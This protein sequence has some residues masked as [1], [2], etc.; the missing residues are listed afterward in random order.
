[1]RSV[2]KGFAEHLPGAIISRP[3]ASLYSVVDLRDVAPADFDASDF[4]GYCARQGR[5]QLDGED[6]TLL[7]AP[8]SGFYG[9]GYP[10]GKFQMRLAY[11]ESPEQMG[12]V[13]R[14][15]AG[16]FAAYLKR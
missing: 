16:L 1:M 14:L 11:V 8:M 3:E 9:D 15:F 5:V 2:A 6:Y 12:K 7:V 13:P 4:V 10:G